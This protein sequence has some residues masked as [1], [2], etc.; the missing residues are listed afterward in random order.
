MFRE[1]IIALIRTAVPAGVGA[2]ITLL[3]D[4]GVEIPADAQ[5]Q[6]TAG[7]ITVCTSAYYFLVT[8]LERQVNPAFGWLLGVAKAPSYDVADPSKDPVEPPD[9]TQGDV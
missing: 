8:T 6:I 9:A 2:V 5:A 7:L 1:S 3:I 4:W